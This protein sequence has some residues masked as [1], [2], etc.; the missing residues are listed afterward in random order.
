VKEYDIVIVGAGPAGSAAA[1][2]LANQNPALAA[3]TVLLDK[4]TFPRLKLCAGGLTRHADDLLKRLAVQPDVPSFPVHA[5]SL[6]FQ[7]LEFTI[8]WRNAFRVVRREEFDTALVRAVQARG[9]EVRQ[10]EAV[11]DLLRDE[12]GVTVVTSRGE[13]RAPVVIG[14]DGANSIVRQ[15]LGLVRADRISRVLEIL[16]PV[17]TARAPEF[18]E[19]TARFDFTPL[20]AGVQGYVWDFPSL[21]QGVPTMNRGLFDARVRPDRPRAELKP[22]FEV[23]LKE[24]DVNLAEEHLMGHPE[25]WFDARVPHSVPRIVLA[26]DAAGAEPLL[27]EGISHALNFGL[28]AAD[29]VMA[30]LARNDFSFRD[31]DRRVAGSALGRRLRAKHFL[32]HFFY[33]NR[34]RWQYRLAWRVSQLI[35]R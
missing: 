15:K 3:R 2:R 20:L 12:T 16:T 35:F 5:V 23:E 25:R 31:Y 17:D 10:G 34:A 7:D 30:A 22:V 27:G 9:V 18:V 21:K 24:R 4:S 28:I 8:P 32:A 13:Y 19:H 33:G 26:G 6:V 14:A 1:L 11:R 29:A